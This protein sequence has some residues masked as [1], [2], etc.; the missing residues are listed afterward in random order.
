MA[1]YGTA[2]LFGQ[3][4]IGTALAGTFGSFELSFVS[5]SGIPLAPTDY[6]GIYVEDSSGPPGG[7]PPPQLLIEGTL[8]FSLS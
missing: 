7:N 6:I 4:R 5:G 3:A 1:N 8:Y 2:S